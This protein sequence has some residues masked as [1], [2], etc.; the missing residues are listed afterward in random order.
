MNCPKCD[1][2]V[3]GSYQPAEFDVGIMNSGWYCDACDLFIEDDDDGS[4]DYLRDTP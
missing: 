2:D 4:D 3:D 1:A